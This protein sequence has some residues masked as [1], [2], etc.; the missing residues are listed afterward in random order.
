MSHLSS[1]NGPCDLPVLLSLYLL[2]P[3]S[4]H[5]KPLN[6][7]IFFLGLLPLVLLN[8]APQFLA[9]LLLGFSRLVDVLLLLDLSLPVSLH[10]TQD[11]LPVVVLNNRSNMWVRLI[12][13]GTNP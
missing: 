4:P 11:T 3:L 2:S 6:P 1:L 13:I 12:L 5:A 9:D 8:P 7:P 10:L